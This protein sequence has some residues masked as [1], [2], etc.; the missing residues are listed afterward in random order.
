MRGKFSLIFLPLTLYSLI[1]SFLIPIPLGTYPNEGNHGI[2]RPLTVNRRP[3]LVSRSLLVV[4]RR[5]VL[6]GWLA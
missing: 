6:V 2:G 5:P 1:P 3:S 4:N